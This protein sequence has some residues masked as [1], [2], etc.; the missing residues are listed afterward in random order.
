MRDSA[1]VRAR[2]LRVVLVVVQVLV[3]A[4]PSRPALQ[5]A[6]ELVQAG[7]PPLSARI[8]GG[9]ATLCCCGWLATCIGMTG[10]TDRMH[11]ACL[12]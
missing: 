11:A 10:L 9:P 5:C 6:Y 2:S 8:R 12:P 7:R 3:L 4:L 1:E